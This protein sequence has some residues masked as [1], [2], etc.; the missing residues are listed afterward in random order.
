VKLITSAGVKVYS[1]YISANGN[2]SIK[3]I[4]DGIYRVLFETGSNWDTDTGV[5]LINPSA[6]EFDNN[7]DFNKYGEYDISLNPVSGGTAVTP[8]INP[9][10]F[11]QY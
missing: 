8:S 6:E 9:S 3:N 2:Y 7:F 5:F 1:V 10:E 11:N 4:N